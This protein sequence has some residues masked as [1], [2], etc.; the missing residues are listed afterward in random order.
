M[1][2]DSKDHTDLLIKHKSV[3]EDSVG[4]KA[5][6]VVPTYGILVHGISTELNAAETMDI[7]NRIKKDNSSHQD[8]RITY[9]GWLKKDITGKR[10][11][12]MVIEFDNPQHA[13][14]AILKG[15]VSGA[16]MFTCEYYDR[17][18]KLKQYFR[19]QQ[20]GHIGTH[21][22]AVETCNYCAGHHDS[23]NC[24]DRG[25]TPKPD[26]KCANCGGKHPAW[27]PHCTKRKAAYLQLEE[28][29]NRQP[30]THQGSMTL[31]ATWTTVQTSKTRT[32]TQVINS[33]PSN[34]L[35]SGTKSDS[36]SSLISSRNSDLSSETTMT[37]ADPILVL[38]PS[39]TQLTRAT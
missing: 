4:P 9:T 16:Q 37:N 23:R 21:C 11:S 27:S 10:A 18:C 36:N 25:K 24:E 31:Q 5:K 28:A 30:H 7:E 29:R 14:I 19:C 38:A 35:N 33:S 3:W 39:Y 12:T 8:A 15:L 34:S 13:D 6:V 22:K 17:S 1:Y 2:T 20:Y 32:C 26:S